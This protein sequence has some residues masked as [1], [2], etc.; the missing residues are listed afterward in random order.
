MT[1]TKTLAHTPGR[2]FGL[3]IQCDPLGSVHVMAVDPSGRGPD[4][5]PHGPMV[6]L[7]EAAA[8]TLRDA[9]ARHLG[10]SEAAA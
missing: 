1:A 2:R 6:A 7:D 5:L 8:E 9:L 10:S 4:S 3:L